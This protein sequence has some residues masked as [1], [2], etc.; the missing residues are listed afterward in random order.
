MYRF[1][2]LFITC[3]QYSCRTRFKASLGNWKRNRKAKCK[4]CGHMI[5]AVEKPKIEEIIP[6]YNKMSTNIP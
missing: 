4:K 6:Q 3:T 5:H 2:E 1:K